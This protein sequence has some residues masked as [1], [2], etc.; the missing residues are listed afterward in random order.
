MDQFKASPQA[1]KTIFFLRISK[2]F[3]VG[4]H[5]RTIMLCILHPF[6]KADWSEG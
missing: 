5:V 6:F 2:L 4:E 1:A 3:I